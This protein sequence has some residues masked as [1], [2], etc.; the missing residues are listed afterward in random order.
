[1]KTFSKDSVSVDEQN[2]RYIVGKL[3]KLPEQHYYLRTDELVGWFDSVETYLDYITEKMPTP[4]QAKESV[5][6]GD[7]Y[8][9]DTYEKAIDV[10]RNDPGSV[11]DFKEIPAEDIKQWDEIGSDI[12]YGVTGDFV[13]IG[14]YMH[15]IPE[16]FGSMHN[17]NQRRYTVNLTLNVSYRGS[18][19]VKTI[20]ER[21]KH[22]VALVDW[23]ELN[24]VRT[25]ITAVKSNECSHI[26]I[27]VKELHELLD[28]RM[29]AVTSHSDFLRRA[30]FRFSEYSDTFKHNY[31]SAVDYGSYT[32]S[33][34]RDTPEDKLFG[35]SLDVFVDSYDTDEDKYEQQFADL[36]Q[37]IKLCIENEKTERLVV[38]R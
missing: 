19:S 2:S 32:S 6:E 29:L 31:G 11:L 35:T 21:L 1:M 13:D 10:Y 16:V 36:R 30:T 28:L 22:V 23:L 9:F 20:N 24:N 27:N 4:K 5:G 12:S 33:E 7:F 37:S 15:G 14:R 17:G 3:N 26:E 38:L 8:Q 18:T 34:Y 25:S